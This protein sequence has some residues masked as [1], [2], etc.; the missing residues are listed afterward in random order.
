MGVRRL[1]ALAKYS[2]L[3]ERTEAPRTVVERFVWE[4]KLVSIRDDG[5][6]VTE[7]E[8]VELDVWSTRETAEV[9]LSRASCGIDEISMAEAV[10]CN[11]LKLLP[12]GCQRLCC[13]IKML[14]VCSSWEA[15]Q[16]EAK[17][18]GEAKTMAGQPCCF[19]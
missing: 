8:L 9:A 10:S 1:D 4:E 11:A 7:I 12:S 19:L 14:L 15:Q 17:R 5:I 18:D 6:L 13:A 16:L 3:K 2:S